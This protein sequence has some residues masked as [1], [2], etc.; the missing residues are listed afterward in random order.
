M[1]RYQKDNPI[2]PAPVVEAAGHILQPGL[3]DG[4][5][6]Q[7]PSVWRPVPA[8]VQGEAGLQSREDKALA[9]P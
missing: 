1:R 4:D 6:G 3:A 8:S 2:F 5:F 7:P 9:V